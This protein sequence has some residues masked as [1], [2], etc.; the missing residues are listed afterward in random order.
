MAR[1][2]RPS[3]I[4]PEHVATAR[5][6]AAIGGALPTI[7]AATNTPLRTI[8]SWLERARAGTGCDLCVALLRAIQNGRADAEKAALIKI[9]ESRDTR[10][11]QWWLTHHPTTRDTWSDAAATRREVARVMGEVCAVIEASDLTP[12]Q[13]ARILLSMQA[14]GLGVQ[15]QGDGDGDG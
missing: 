14:R 15:Q 11:A 6:I 9:T 4:T 5:E 2:G 13:Q 7:A 12:E 8:E 3:T 10:D 1:I